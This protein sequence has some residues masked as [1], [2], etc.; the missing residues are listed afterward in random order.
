MASKVECPKCVGLGE[1]FN[2]RF[3]K[4]CKLCGGDKIVDEEAAEAY[5]ENIMEDEDIY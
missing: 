5:L 4:R 3:M 1:E 2:G